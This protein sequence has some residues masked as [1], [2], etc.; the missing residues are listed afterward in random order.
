MPIVVP[1]VAV[2]AGSAFASETEK[3]SPEAV[4]S[5]EASST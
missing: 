5:M 1:A 2:A 4:V 3:M